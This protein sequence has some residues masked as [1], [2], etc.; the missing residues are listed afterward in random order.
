M[1]RIENYGAL[2][3]E[4]LTKDF[5]I[6]NNLDE[7][8]STLA[9]AQLAKGAVSDGIDSYVKAKDPSQAQIL[10]KKKKSP[11]FDL[12]SKYTRASIDC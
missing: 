3:C 6:A 4:N 9:A 10:Q 8:W 7:T 5:A 12:A 11:T 1:I 2:T